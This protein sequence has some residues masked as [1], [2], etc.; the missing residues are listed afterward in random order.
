MLLVF[1]LLKSHFKSF[2]SSSIFYEERKQMFSKAS[3]QNLCVGFS[4]SANYSVS[5]PSWEFLPPA[6]PRSKCPAG[7]G[8]LSPS[9]ALFLSPLVSLSY[10]DTA[11]RRWPSAI[12]D[13]ALC[14]H[15]LHWDLDLRL[16]VS[17]T[18][19]KYISVD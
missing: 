5:F 3:N 2:C 15:L 16:P 18:V 9:L 7:P 17:R 10:E 1:F 13:R 19:R 8:P 4:F 11:A 6:P 14:K 12:Q